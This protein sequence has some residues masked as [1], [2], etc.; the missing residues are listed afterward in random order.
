ML[1]IANNILIADSIPELLDYLDSFHL[2]HAWIEINGKIRPR[3]LYRLYG[4]KK[5]RAYLDNK[6]NIVSLRELVNIC[7]TN[8]PVTDEELAEWEKKN[9]HL[10]KLS[11]DLS[12]EIWAKIQERINN[13][14]K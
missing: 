1:Y 6:I 2:S 12:Q 8:H 13:Q 14:K 9:G 4:K 7:K 3:I 11:K 10:P 5:E